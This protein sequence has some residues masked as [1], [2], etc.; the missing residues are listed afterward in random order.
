MTPEDLEN[1]LHQ[2]LQARADADA[3]TRTLATLSDALADGL[4][5]YFEHLDMDAAGA[6]LMIVAESLASHVDRDLSPAM[7]LRTLLFAGANLTHTARAR[8]AE[9]AA[10][11][12]DVDEQLA[13]LEQRLGVALTDPKWYE[14]TILWC[15]LDGSPPVEIPQGEPWV[16]PGE[17]VAVG[18]FHVSSRQIPAQGTVSNAQKADHRDGRLKDLVW[19]RDGGCCRYC[20]SGPLVHDNARARDRRRVLQ[21]DHVDP[22]QP[23]GPDSENYVVACG[24][25]NEVK[26]HRTPDAAGLV[27]LPAPV[28]ATREPESYVVALHDADRLGYL[29]PSDEWLNGAEPLSEE[30]QH[31]ADRLAAHGRI[32]DLRSRH[33]DLG[34]A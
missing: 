29:A 24:A 17:T 4:R 33:L 5:T 12:P 25:C 34:G 15:P 19:A 13:D 16:L 21:F 10:A 28:Q 26:G 7:L 11:E 18:Q 6:V 1:V 9:T 27:L 22:D 3:L 32:P 31:V 2:T 14:H 8:A 20:G 30:L 23:A